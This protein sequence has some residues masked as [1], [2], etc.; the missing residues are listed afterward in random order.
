MMA[1]YE[2]SLVLPTYADDFRTLTANLKLGIYDRDNVMRLSELRNFNDW[3]IMRADKILI[4]YRRQLKELY[5]TLVVVD[6]NTPERILYIQAY[7]RAS[8]AVTGMK[9]V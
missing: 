4:K 6:T 2:D 9:N 8:E 1:E 7:Q 3:D 5:D